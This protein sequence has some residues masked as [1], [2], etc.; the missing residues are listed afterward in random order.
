MYCT[1][2][3]L[4]LFKQHFQKAIRAPWSN[5]NLKKSNYCNPKSV[6]KG[7][8]YSASEQANLFLLIKWNP[9]RNESYF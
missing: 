1:S 9:T 3:K 4:L 2:I 6:E 8:G 5:K 7:L